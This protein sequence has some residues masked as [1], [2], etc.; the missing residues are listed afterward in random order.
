MPLIPQPALPAFEVQLAAPDIGRWLAGNTGVSGFTTR[1]SGAAG[2]HVALL[3]LSHG[4]EIAGAIALDRLLRSGLV[5]ACG[6]LTFGFMNLAAF[7]RFDPRQPTASRFVDEDL[8]RLWDP[9]VLDGARRSTELGSRSGDPTVDRDGRCA[10]GPA[11]DAVA[12][13]SAHPVRHVRNEGSRLALGAGVPGLVVAD[14]GHASRTA[15]DPI[16]RALPMPGMSVPPV[17]WRRGSTGRAGTVDT[18]LASIAGAAA[19]CW[20]RGGMRCVAAI[21]V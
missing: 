21:R 17:W 20:C 9:G 13:G 3:A 4:N 2:P 1:G 14:H 5:P 12:V 16:I 6:K 10:A 19:A 8:N 15:A 7:E 18:M 11:F